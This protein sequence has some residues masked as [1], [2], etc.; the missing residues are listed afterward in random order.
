[1]VATMI[2]GST[3]KVIKELFT[4]YGVAVPAGHVAATA[5]EAGRAA[6]RLGGAL[7]VVNSTA[8]RAKP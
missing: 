5:E 8:A 2:S 1:M 7:W 3:A 4:R 6:E